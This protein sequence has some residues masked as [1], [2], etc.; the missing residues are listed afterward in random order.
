MGN[1]SIGAD[2]VRSVQTERKAV[3]VLGTMFILFFMSWASFFSMNLAMGLCPTCHFEELL[4]KWFLWLGYSSSIINPIIYTVFNRAFKKTFLRLLTCGLKRSFSPCDAAAG[5][6]GWSDGG[7]GESRHRCSSVGGGSETVCDQ[8]V[9][10]K[11]GV[12]T[13]LT[14]QRFLASIGTMNTSY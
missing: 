7:V 2:S 3:K 6:F 1:I 11:S 12:T 5:G 4:Y 14:A 8:T 13:L 9:A 10:P